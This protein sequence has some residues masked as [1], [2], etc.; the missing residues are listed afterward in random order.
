MIFSENQVDLVVLPRE[1]DELQMA[2]KDSA[3]EPAIGEP[4]KGPPQGIPTPPIPSRNVTSRTP[5]SSSVASASSSEE[6]LVNRRGSGE[7]KPKATRLQTPPYAHHPPYTRSLT[8]SQLPVPPPTFSSVTAQSVPDMHR[9]SITD[10][11]KPYDSVDESSS[12]NK[13]ERLLK[14]GESVATRTAKFE[15]FA[16]KSSP[17]P[18]TVPFY[19]KDGDQPKGPSYR[20]PHRPALRQNSYLNAINSPNRNCK[21]YIC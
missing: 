17:K 10:R 21:F 8:T 19:F 16:S 12:S 4:Y 1:H 2:Y 6:R 13:Q 14:C 9:R 20:R 18:E 3:Y 5:S 7:D 15:K 11:M